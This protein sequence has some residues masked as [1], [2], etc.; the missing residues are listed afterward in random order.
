MGKHLSVLLKSILQIA[1]ENILLHIIT[2]CCSGAVQAPPSVASQRLEK[3]VGAIVNNLY[4][5]LA[6]LPLGR[7]LEV[8][9]LY[10]L[11]TLEKSG[12]IDLGMEDIDIV[13][14]M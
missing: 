14:A 6:R 5:Q 12:I 2:S 9:A 7:S 13:N 11:D 1:H 4:I 8:S 10:H 3:S